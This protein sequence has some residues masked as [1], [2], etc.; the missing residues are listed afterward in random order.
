MLRELT[1]YDDK[2]ELVC[3]TCVT[4]PTIEN[5]L[6]VLET[7]PD[8]KPGISVTVQI[9]PEFSWGDGTPVTA[10]DFK[11]RWEIGRHPD[12]GSIAPSAF[13]PVYQFDVVDD[14]TFVLHYDE[15]KY[16]FN[17]FW[18]IP[19]IPS[20]LERS[21]YEQDPETYKD[22]SLYATNPTNPG[23]W[24]GPYRLERVTPGVELTMVRNPYW[25]GEQPRFDSVTLRAIENTAALEANL[26]S[27]SIDM[28][29][30]QSNGLQID[31]GISFEKR[32]GSDYQV[33]YTHKALLELIIVQMKKNPVLADKRVRQALLYALDREGINQQ[34]FAGKQPVAHIGDRKYDS[35]PEGVPQYNYDPQRAITLLEQ[36]GWD[37][38]K[39]GI[40]HNSAGEPLQFEL[41]STSGNKSREL[42][43]QAIQAQ[44]KAV[45][46]DARIKNQTARV[47]F[48]QS[49]RKR[50]FKALSLMGTS[51]PADRQ[52]R[53]F[54]SSSY[55]GG[56]NPMGY[57]NPEV[58]RLV[59]AYER[60]LD[61]AKRRQYGE[62]IVR[63]VREEVPVLLLYWRPRVD[64]LPLDLKGFRASGHKVP[65]S[66]WIEEWRWEKR[67]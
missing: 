36:A 48:G 12:A 41:L 61:A 32:H 42:I 4:L 55:D 18:L 54:H 35:V 58:D 63:I 39:N 20:Q 40:R 64:V 62:Q 10:E 65:D 11:L 24:N 25:F 66:N 46:V 31:Q 59:E 26:L 49:M 53:P 28:I 2:S 57:S 5:G 27:G 23:L 1:I 51:S 67:L 9:H 15:I 50:T 21:I 17:D 8:G 33:L 6:A 30:G 37:K 29:A 19:P 45:G 52:Y 43:Q 16:S 7:T 34:L 47:F 13:E 38:I 60:E 22:R 14:K 56:K 3:R 44:L